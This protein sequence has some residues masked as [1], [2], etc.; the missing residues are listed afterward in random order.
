MLLLAVAH[1]PI[2]VYS[3]VN[4]VKSI[5]TN[6]IFILDQSY[7]HLEL[8]DLPPNIVY[9]NYTHKESINYYSRFIIGPGLGA[10]NRSLLPQLQYRSASIMLCYEDNN[11]EMVD[12]AQRLQELGVCSAYNMLANSLLFESLLKNPI[13]A[14][15]TD[16]DCDGTFQ[17][18]EYIGQLI[19]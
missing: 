11:S 3:F 13:E 5:H 6:T 4:L 10:L 9:S 14:S 7:V 17:I 19:Q 16:F 12:N 1:M 15:N 2:P 8:T 18:V